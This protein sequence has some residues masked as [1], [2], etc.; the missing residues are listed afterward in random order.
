MMSVSLRSKLLL[1]AALLLATGC[2]GHGP[3]PADLAPDVLYAQATA[4][5]EAGRYGKAVELLS[6]FVD[7]QSGDPRAPEARLMLGRAYAARREYVSAATEFQRLITDYPASPLGEQARFGICD[8]YRRLS[9]KPQ[10]DQEYTRSA[11]LHCESV[12]TLFPGTA[13]ADSATSFVA[14][15]NNKLARKLYENGVF[16]LRRRAYDA[17]AIYLNQVLALY[18]GSPSAP[19]AL[20]RLVEAYT[21][22]GYVEEADAAKA[23][24]RSDYPESAEARALGQ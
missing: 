17:A 14:E 13:H 9:P 6:A 19:A 22:M 7:R 3:R 20:A 16:Y 12:A 4:A 8:A 5:F 21:R 15:L 10:L 18:P 24:L 23:R 11:L 1:A 2:A